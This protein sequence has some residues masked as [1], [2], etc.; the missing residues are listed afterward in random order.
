MSKE[1]AHR[2]LDTAQK[3]LH[4]YPEYLKIYNSALGCDGDW[5]TIDFMQH[6]ATLI[7]D[8]QN[9]INSVDNKTE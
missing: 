8:A 6:V 4:R 1:R 3:M 9:M 7:K 5:E 2:N